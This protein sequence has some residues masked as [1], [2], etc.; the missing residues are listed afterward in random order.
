VITE[1]DEFLFDLLTIRGRHLFAQ[2][3]CS[4]WPEGEA[5]EKNGIRRA[6]HFLGVGLLGQERVFARPLLSISAP[7]HR[8][9]E[10]GEPDI[11]AVAYKLMSRWKQPPKMH[12]VFFATEKA[13]RFFGGVGRTKIA[14]PFQVTHDAMTA[15]VYLHY[16][17][18]DP[19]RAARWLGEDYLALAGR[20][21]RKKVDAVIFD[22]GGH[23][24]LAMDFGGEYRA[25]RVLSVHSSLRR[26][27]PYELW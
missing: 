7:V 3:W 15:Q 8:Y 4:L 11:H 16:H 13:A 12:R 20:E 24:E 22:E 23:P 18:T 26:I 2:Q 10:D 27:C 9:P 17:R 14:Q 6:E 19:V 21:I 1:R 5:G 25:D